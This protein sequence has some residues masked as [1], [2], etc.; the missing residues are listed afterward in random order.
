MI[1]ESRSLLPYYWIIK[2]NG[3]GTGKGK[4][5]A[6]KLKKVKMETE[7]LLNSRNK[8]V[9]QRNNEHNKTNGLKQRAATVKGAT[10]SFNIL[11]TTAFKCKWFLLWIEK[12]KVEQER[13]TISPKSHYRIKRPTTQL[14]HLKDTRL[15]SLR[16]KSLHHFPSELS[17]L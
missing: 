11:S 4:E 8:E 16:L 2:R 10:L 13:L 14:R 5:L 15:I 12:G 3:K 17:L 6:Q 9:Y 7:L 1:K